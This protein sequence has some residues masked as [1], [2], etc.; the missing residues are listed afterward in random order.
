MDWAPQRNLPAIAQAVARCAIHFRLLDTLLTGRAYLLRG[1]ISLADL[2]IGAALYR[3]F[4]LDI[5]RPDLPHVTAW[6]KRLQQRPA[7]CGH[8]M[9]PFT[10]MRGRLAY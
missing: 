7:F 6:Y 2:P 1:T 3:Y 5:E 10:E 8:V 9:V 4:E